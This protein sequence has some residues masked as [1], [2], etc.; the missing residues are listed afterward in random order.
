MQ[1]RQ[2]HADKIDREGPDLFEVMNANEKQTHCTLQLNPSNGL[3][4]DFVNKLN[5]VTNCVTLVL[6]AEKAGGEKFTRRMNELGKAIQSMPTYTEYIEA[7]L[8]PKAHASG[9]SDLK[10]SSFCASTH[11][12]ELSSTVQRLDQTMLAV[13]ECFNHHLDRPSEIQTSRLN[14]LLRD[15]YRILFPERPERYEKGIEQ[16]SPRTLDPL[17]QRQGWTVIDA[18]GGESPLKAA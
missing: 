15:A 9:L 4:N 3:S 1:E 18:S 5:T 10:V 16:L 12:R 13:R 8:L 14:Q 2:I 11:W 7:E 17:C 6:L